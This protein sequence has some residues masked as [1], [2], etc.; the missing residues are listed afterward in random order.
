MRHMR[1]V[2][3]LE[4]VALGSDFDGITCPLEMVDASG[5]DQLVRAMEGEGFTEREI[6]AICWGNVWRFYGETLG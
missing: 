5:M 1:D 3:G 2:G 6:D 4:V